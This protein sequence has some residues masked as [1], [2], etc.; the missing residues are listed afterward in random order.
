[1]AQNQALT[2]LYNAIKDQGTNAFV[3][4]A[5]FLTSG[6]N[7]S[8]ITVP[9]DY[10]DNVVKAFQQD[11][12]ESF[13]VT[14]SDDTADW[15]GDDQFTLNK[16]SLPVFNK[17]VK[18]A[19]KLLF[20]IEDSTLIVQIYS[21]LSSWNWSDSFPFMK[22][23][24][25]NKIPLKK[26]TFI[27][28]TQDGNYPWGSTDSSAMKVEAGPV[29]NISTDIIPPAI[30]KPVASLFSNINFPTDYIGFYGVLNL[31]DYDGEKVQYPTTQVTA[32]FPIINEE[33]GVSLFYLNVS[34]PKITLSIPPP[35][36]KEDNGEKQAN[37]GDDDNTDQSPG[38][39]VQAGISIG[40]GD[41]AIAYDLSAEIL[42][43][44]TNSFRFGL[45][46]QE[47]ANILSP[48]AVLKLFD[49]EGSYFS[50]TP[51][52]LQQYLTEIGLLGF[53]L[54]GI[55]GE[56]SNVDT[57][58][59]SIGSKP[60]T[61]FTP[62]TDP[63]NSLDFT[64]KGFNLNWTLLNPLC[65]D[66]DVSQSFV[67]HTSFDLTFNPDDG[68]SKLEFTIEF[69]SDLQFSA[70]ADGTLS[71]Q[72][73]IST[74][75]GG[76]ISL[77]SSVQASISDISL[78]M[79]NKQGS[80]DFN[81]GFD[82]SLNF[83]TLNNEPVLQIDGGQVEISAI[84]PSS[85]SN[86]G[87]ANGQEVGRFAAATPQTA[88]KA[89]VSGLLGVGPFAANASVE[90]DGQQN[91]TRWNISASLAEALEINKLINLF[92]DP[93][94][95][96]QLPTEFFPGDPKIKTFSI[97]AVIPSGQKKVVTVQGL[98]VMVPSDE[99]DLATTY[100]IETTFEW[101]FTLG[102][103]EVGIDNAT[104]KVD[105]DSS[106]DEGLQ[107]TGSAVGSWI[108][109]DIN[110]ELLLGYEFKIIDNKS[111]QILFAEWE[112][113]R[114]EYNITNELLSFSLKGWTLGSLIQALVRT[115][116]N[117]YFTLNAPWDLLDK[118]SLDGLSVI[119]NMAKDVEDRVSASYTL[120]SPLNLGFM[121]IESLIFRKAPK[122]NG[123]GSQI[124]LAMKATI[125]P[126]LESVLEGANKD[127]FENLTNENK[128]QD[129]ND[130]PTVPGQGQEY[131]KLFLLVLGQKIGISGSA[132]FNNTKEVICALSK[133]PS[134][135]TTTNPVDPAM[136]STPGQP[137][138][139]AS[140][141]WLIATHMGI[142]K[143]GQAWTIDAMLV[144]NDPNLYGLRLAL[145]GGKAGGLAGLSI[146]ILY[147][148]IT[149][150]VGVFQIEFTFPD[151]IRKINFG[152]V[153]ITLP[154]IG[155]KIYTNGDFFIDI[156]FPYNLDFS[157]SFS[158]S[159]IIYG[160]PVIGSG[161]FYFGKLSGATSTQVPQT[162]KGTFKP[163][164]EFGLGLQLGLGYNF[165][166]GPLSAGF[167][168][169]VFG[170]IEGVIAT[171]HPYDS[172]SQA[173]A[174]AEDNSVQ[175]SNYFKITGMV[176]II[177]LMYGK[178]DFAIIQ[179]SLNIKIS[180]SLQITYESYKAIPLIAT[181]SVDVSLKVKVLFVKISIS[182]HMK[183]SAKFVIGT[184]ELDK[185]PWYDGNDTEAFMLRSSALLSKGPAAIRL[186]A[187]QINP[188]PKRLVLDTDKPT[189]NLVLA[190]QFTV[191]APESATAYTDQQ[192]AFVTLM[193]IDAP[194]ATQ[195]TT[196]PGDTSFEQLCATYFPWLID[197]LQKESGDVVTLKAAMASTVTQSQLEDF[198]DRLANTNDPALTI[199]Q[200]LSFL[201]DSFI[202]DIST[203]EN[204]MGTAAEAQLENGATLFPFFDG[205]SLTVPA[206][207]GTGTSTIDLE[208][209]ATANTTYQQEVAK[210]LAEVEAQID[211][212][213]AP[214]ENPMPE[215]DSV[216]SMSSLVFVDTF[217]MI[218]RQLLLAAQNALDD[219]SYSLT[220]TD[221]ISGIV[222][223]ANAQGNHLTNEDIVNS[224]L[225]HQLTAGISL[226]IRGIQYIIQAQDTLS[227]VANKF[228][229][230]S[231]D[232]RW[233]VHEKQIIISNYMGRVLNGG[234]EIQLKNSEDQTV[235][236]VTIVGDFFDNIA[237]SLGISIDNLASQTV[238]Y[239]TE[240]LLKS[241]SI[242]SI[243]D[244]TYE[245]A[246]A[247]A[248]G[249]P[250][251][252]TLQ[253]IARFF[254]LSVTDLADD[255]DA[256]ENIYSV[257]ANDGVLALANLS[258]LSVSELWDAIQATAQVAQTAGMVSRFLMFGLRLPNASGLSL[259][260]GFLYSKDQS[261]YAF[262]QLTGQQFPTPAT[263]TDTFPLTISRADS[264]HGVDLSF[265]TF[266]STEDKSATADLID[267]FNDLTIVLDWAKAGNFIP[268]PSI[269]ILPLSDVIAKTLSLNSFAQWNS[270]DFSS[271]I[272]LTNRDGTLTEDGS[273]PQA[274][275]WPLPNSLT[276]DV[277]TLQSNISALFPSSELQ[278]VLNLLPQYVPQV[279][280]SSPATNRTQFTNI[281]Q[282]AW[283][284]R[285]D[286]EIKRLPLV[287]MDESAKE[288]DQT[289]PQ[290]PA[291]A[292]SIPN[293]Y[294]M[295]GPSD[296]AGLLLDQL[297]T[298]M[299]ALGEDIASAVFLLYPQGPDSPTGLST[300][301]D[302]EFLSFITQTNL[303]TETNPLR[304]AALALATDDGSAPRGIANSPGEFVKLLWELSTVRSG[305]YFLYYQ[306]VES[307]DGLPSSIF[308]SSGT[309][310][311]SMVVTYAASGSFSF[312]NTV[313]NFVNSFVTTDAIDTSNDVVQ[314]LSQKALANSAA[315]TSTDSLASLSAIYGS[316]VGQIALSNAATSLVQAK[317][318][319]L[320]GLVHQ[321]TEKEVQDTSQTLNN[322]AA[323]YSVGAKTPITAND[324]SNFNPGVSVELGAVYYIPPITYVIGNAT[325]GSN[326][327]SIANYYNINIEALAVNAMNVEGIFTEKSTVSINS[328]QFDLRSTLG[329]GNIGF[330]LDRVNM[331][332]PTTL[333]SDPT[334]AQKDEYAAQYMYM[335]YNTLSAGIESNVFFKSSALGLPFGPQTEDDNN[336]TQNAEL[337]LA[338][339]ASRQ[340]SKRAFLAAAQDDDYTYKQALGFGSKS[341]VDPAAK[342]AAAAGITSTNPYI[343]VGSTTQVGLRWQD[344]FGNTTITPFEKVPADYTGAI[345]GEAATIKY[346]DL[347]IGIGE[348]PNTQTSHIYRS[349]S[350]ASNLSIN[351]LFD[352]TAY[353]GL[354][355]AKQQI[356][357]DLAKYIQI[358]F[359]LNQDYSDLETPIP[360]V[361]GN[362]VT[363][364]LN[365]A[366][367][368]NPIVDL[369]ESQAGQI[370]TYVVDCINY[371]NSLLADT[372]GTQP[373]A[374]LLFP[375][376]L[377]SLVDGNI[378]ELDLSLTIKRKATLTE[379]N[380]AGLDKGL[381]ATS[382]IL[383]QADQ[384]ETA[385]YTTYATA[386]EA[387]FQDDQWFMKVGEGLQEQNDDQSQV[388][389]QLWT[390][391]FGKVAG[392]GVFFKIGDTASYYTPE[393]VATALES[394][395]VSIENYTTGENTTSDFSGV[396]LNLW[397]Q[398]VLDAVDEFLSAEDSTSVFILDKI[399]GTDDPLQD[400]YLGK[401][402]NSKRSL[403]DNISSTVKPI[404]ST[405]ASDISSI[406][407]AA[408]KI[409]QQ[410]L[411]Q[412]GAA[413]KA[414]ATI[415]FDLEDV[416]G[417]SE[418]E[419]S[420]P[421][422]LY[423]QPVG[424][425][426]NED[427]A[428]QNFSLTAATIPLA[429]QS[430]E[431]NGN[432]EQI[433]PRLAF[434]F[435]SKNVLQE[436]YVPLEMEYKI[437]HLEFDRQTVPGIE[438]YVESRWLA[439]VNGPFTYKL[440]GGVSNIPV[441]NRALP[442]PPSVQEQLAQK[443]IDEPSTAEELTKWDYSFNYTYD[444]GASDVIQLS[445]E[446]NLPPSISPTTLLADEPDLFTALAQFVTN[447]PAVEQD[448][449]T[450]LP[451][452]NE[453]EPDS[454]SV[455]GA[456][457][458]VKA[459]QEYLND[460]AVAYAAHIE[461]SAELA[462]TNTP[463]KVEITFSMFLDKQ[464]ESGDENTE[465]AR[466]DI[467]DIN[468]IKNG[469]TYSATYD[470]Q[471]NTISG[472]DG[473]IVLPAMLIEIE[474]SVYEAEALSDPPENVT[475]A[476]IYQNINNSD[477][478]L[479]YE[480]ALQIPDRIV[481][482]NTL[483][484]LAYQDA[485]SS[486]YVQRNKILFPIEDRDHIST[487]EYFLF[488]TPV[489]KFANVI[490]PR[491]VFTE[492]NLGSAKEANLSTA[493]KASLENFFKEL[494]TE[495][496][497]TTSIEAAMTSGYAYTLNAILENE[498]RTLIPISMLPPTEAEVDPNSIPAFV[499][500]FSTSI[501]DWVSNNQPTLDGKPSINMELRIFGGLTSKQPLLVVKNLIFSVL[502]NS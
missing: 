500:I 38:L 203:H 429:I 5:S 499:D 422:N 468:I 348:W 392:V 132:D 9:S 476:Y 414:G 41:D 331:G 191:L 452:M 404:L 353:D 66:E 270:S 28:T 150:D 343:G 131:F 357:K 322:L 365:N 76:G 252:D 114:A 415:V 241:S 173:L 197:A 273:Q 255:N 470:A 346:N 189:L 246:P 181:V 477:E 44:E 271:L 265:I 248:A 218:G 171:F 441:V 166:A 113:F 302:S 210:T 423:G 62:I 303:S 20:A 15:N 32:Y 274:T 243:P 172:N 286:F 108:Y 347:L 479:T 33:K 82:V 497:G 328:E 306:D 340:A 413:Y 116:G 445:I 11:K 501:T 381:T 341:K 260:D 362:A 16:I 73:L 316:G 180:I 95:N 324:I 151:A 70:K 280:T 406:S 160:V 215:E 405:S 230:S 94:G 254:G 25:F 484:V 221:T 208:E 31:K 375:V 74:V 401:V 27:F 193:A 194:D 126:G 23:F 395:S 389:Q 162:T 87:S 63:S 99:E 418:N 330:Q 138:Y 93:G 311:L 147:K 297:L 207:S 411:N 408:E 465:I 91:P 48:G 143:V 120:S 437:S 287:S 289:T 140:N 294:E 182:F 438:G 192:G 352:T 141:N 121:T 109:S 125:A 22:G 288:G 462:T 244:F 130:M 257:A 495:G 26:A 485:W 144:F 439:F 188:K 111:N 78:V 200:L 115:I 258:A 490:I 360:G 433:Q 101:K 487:T 67:F 263:A 178:L 282:W 145:G 57:V 256:V 170:I 336:N 49:N 161:G 493:L 169:T 307:G 447:Y 148:K 492:F 277:A 212:D 209:Y 481:S 228:T 466:V 198:V 234:V 460:V 284:T 383:P 79:D 295:V 88:Y 75:S 89:K 410:L 309:A 72:D 349:I 42:K 420:Q 394:D 190:P 8:S 13:E 366:L 128:G 117:P 55:V 370:S 285:V 350:D 253:S 457:K 426:D 1:M 24:P 177:G 261:A 267:A 59:A 391:R 382:A 463:E 388:N 339:K 376:S 250:S 135:D 292:P 425:I 291:S 206:A 19:G 290:G 237:S 139:E 321:L 249:D 110:F 455:Q 51:A 305:G 199:A 467:F 475:I 251:S 482:M 417:G 223:W 163:V 275:L 478:Y 118:V 356:E 232:D 333:P 4:D 461:P 402:L 494:F 486:I 398:T 227:A 58:A 272:A 320:Q 240:G 326:F 334:Q 45:T 36:K 264:A 317:E 214:Q 269:E 7:D 149:D 176:G 10:D 308:D 473:K 298:A 106:R 80:Y 304:S 318:I 68:S 469:T 81:A 216:Q 386:F 319:P 204:V 236:Y 379:A 77:P 60:G 92:F 435:N 98:E 496:D 226:D 314:L 231:T 393:P 483:D 474:P 354:D 186:A 103:A 449:K 431:N 35:A 90:Y 312:G 105:Y 372:T 123:N 136:G 259:S 268:T 489:V 133:V 359:Q 390:V 21:P 53:S 50:G 412:I 12:I 456:E 84:T 54:S 443:A 146:D 471:T 378:I 195:N 18:E 43:D 17:N 451:K 174:L 211:Y 235:P 344:L 83:L 47:D 325:V 202:L 201:D 407:T 442:T 85:D 296:E 217:M 403:A 355:N 167:A 219:Y 64:F 96:Y 157:R 329:P 156:G 419:M 397:F 225:T 488:Q 310:T 185:A 37:D 179:A 385:A 40:E 168:L 491:L 100:N 97:D 14:V 245:T 184:D 434:V 220:S 71:I 428:N 301:G 229:D 440:G 187:Q 327:E 279:G 374:D 315:I 69:N 283:T 281:D 323:Y 39:E 65:D 222:S 342:K 373:T 153:N 107:Y 266:N 458:A 129:V 368:K 299:D 30:T 427:A 61:E 2:N 416:S 454:A 421:P 165:Q 313:P 387:I 448:L 213:D 233:T 453:E 380:V 338:S 400:G 396:D 377:N 278:D 371:L 196:D 137:Y 3:L 409:K 399:L 300:L 358:F 276:G 34:D 124:T 262:Y 238:L 56:Q 247:A 502:E 119:I 104:I 224:N 345:N 480:D 498:V 159:A 122:E 112:G 367:L 432:T 29:Q 369:T 152:A 164:I 293:V 154:E 335:L 239:T 6:L 155:I 351:F 364:S 205:L 472:D 52:V 332:E 361:T 242:L 450:Y 46:Y 102:S 444:Q 142:L 464:S 337:A 384:G 175:S 430:V 459:F 436:A 183:V 86:N 127:K 363:I 424:S 158:I 134:T 446:L